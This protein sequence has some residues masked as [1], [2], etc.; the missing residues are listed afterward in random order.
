MT[1]PPPPSRRCPANVLRILTDLLRANGI[2]RLYGS[3]CA[4]YGVLSIAYGLTVWCDGRHLW[5]HRD[6]KR[7]T[8]PAGDLDRAARLLLG[9]ARDPGRPQRPDGP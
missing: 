1:A 6:G 4:L 9:L 3:A 2:T 7:T 8:W 5:W